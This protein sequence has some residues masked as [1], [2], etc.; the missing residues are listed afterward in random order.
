M[1][2]IFYKENL[3]LAFKTIKLND[4]G[5]ISDAGLDAVKRM[6]YGRTFN[7]CSPEFGADPTGVKD[8]TPAFQAAVDKAASTPGGGVVIIPGGEFRLAPPFVE[9]KAYVS[10][11]GEGVGSTHIFIDA[12]KVDDS[13][14]ENGA[15]HT[16][17]YNQRVTDKGR[18]RISLSDFSIHTTMPDGSIL[19]GAEGQYQHLGVEYMNNKVWGLVFNTFL[20]N[21]PADPDAV[22][23]IE[24]IEIWDTAGGIALLGLDDQGC[25][26]TNIRVRRTMKQGLLV[27]K[28]FDH[29]EA[30]ETNPTD[31]TKPYR[32]TGAADNK[33]IRMDI[34]GGNLGRGGYAGIEVY[35]SQC[36][37]TQC[38]SWYHKRYTSGDIN[39]S[40][41]GDTANIWNFKATTVDAVAGQINA[42]SDAFRF[43]K[44]GAGWYVPGTRNEF[45]NCTSQETGGHGWV[46]IGALCTYD[47]CRGESAS[48]YDNAKD[49]PAKTGEA[50]GFLVTNW[51][52]GTR[53]AGCLAQNAYKREQAAYC[54]Y[55]IQD[56]VS[57]LRLRDCVTQNMPYVNGVDVTAGEREVIFP[58]NPGAE[59]AL[60]INEKFLSTFDRDK[61]GG[62]APTA[63]ASLPS[64]IG[65]VMAHWDFSNSA[66]ITS[67]AGRV[68]AV[69]LLSGSA[70]DGALVQTDSAKQ[71]WLSSLSGRSAIKTHNAATE[72]LQAPAIGTAPI[73]GGWTVAVAASINSTVNG[74]Y[75]WSTIGAGAVSPTS[76][77]VTEMLGLRGNSNGTTAGVTVKSDDKALTKY[78]PAVL[79]MTATATGVNLYVNGKKYT[80]NSTTAKDLTG[81][82]TVGAYYGGTGGADSTIGEVAAF[83]KA[84]SDN[85]VASLNAYL[86]GK[87]V[88]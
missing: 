34:S 35:T 85:E 74:Q 6:N 58:P 32:R 26:L 37:F 28:P 9:M 41:T 48:Y 63:A 61:K 1:L 17:S 19:R 87:W 86:M 54:G 12:S 50:A 51:A 57:R 77:V 88:N 47:S 71:P 11:R 56:Y 13:T 53:L 64:E 72:F 55:Y 80:Q 44:D 59:V 62:A 23:T 24:N 76:I 83:S 31:A 60:E 70:T 67:S 40:M 81:K 3:P 8:C 29:P 66:T 10:M 16:G 39:A 25:K 22:H 14:T 73:T 2:K 79:I 45:S 69:S 30:Y 49:L 36:M 5:T 43:T 78:A 84:L 75:L 21:G 68:S 15:F 38:T 52:W 82:G 65:S 7:V 46:I 33:F 18:F 20:D 27:G 42:Q 4:D